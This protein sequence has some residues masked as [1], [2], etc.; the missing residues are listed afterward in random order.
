MRSIA[1]LLLLVSLAG[2]KDDPSEVSY[3]DT[4]GTIADAAGPV[5]DADGSVADA[6]GTAA[7]ADGTAADASVISD[8]DAIEDVR[9]TRTIV[10]LAVKKGFPDLWGE[11]AATIKGGGADGV[12]FFITSLSDAEEATLIPA[13]PGVEAHY[14]GTVRGALLLAEPRHIIPRVSGVVELSSGINLDGSTFGNFTYHG[15]LAP[16]GGLSLTNNKLVILRASNVILRF[17]RLRYGRAA[18]LAVDDALLFYRADTFCVDHTS[19]AWAGDETFSVGTTRNRPYPAIIA[20][21]NIIGQT[22]KGHNTGTLIGYTDSS[23]GAEGIV[24]WHNNVYVGV[25]HRTPNFA[26]DTKMY[27]RIF[28]NITYDWESRLTNL[29]G[30]PTVDVAYNYY[31]MGPANTAVPANR[32]N[33]YQDLRASRPYP[34]SIYTAGNIMPGVLTDPDADNQ[35]LWTLFQ[36]VDPVPPELFRSTPLPIDSEVGYQPSS[37]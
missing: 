24:S 10:T 5:A 27:G 20:Q 26:G 31:K 11:G 9:D 14:E 36:S 19:V 13:S 15:H 8:T 18:E 12:K 4:G 16:E 37:A 7:D 6:D 34:P 32:Y 1:V 33:K 21:N 30:A 17:L 23:G 25:T 35:Q 3:N 28:N 22:R 29:V 2:C